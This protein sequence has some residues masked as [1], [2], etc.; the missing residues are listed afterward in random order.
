[1]NIAYLDPAYSRYFHAL[2][3]A[4]RARTGGS[5]VALLS[6]PAYRLYTGDDRTVVWKPGVPERISELPPEFAHATWAPLNDAAS[7][8]AFS[9][10]VEWF[11]Q[12]FLEERIE[13]CLVFSDARPFSVA[14][15][16][17]AQELGVVILYFERGAFRYST[18]SLSTLGLNSRF[19]LRRAQTLPGI[20][21][22]PASEALKRRSVE[23]WLRLRFAKF[24]ARNALACL[25]DRDRGRIQHKRYAIRPYLRLAVAQWWAEHHHE[26]TSAD[27]LTSLSGHPLVIL[28]LQLETDSQL[29]LHSPFSGNQHFI[30]FVVAQVRNLVPEAVVL[31]KRHPM[32]ASRY[33]VPPGARM[34]G[35]NLARFHAARPIFVCV[36]STVGFEALVRGERVI[37][38]APSFYA[39]AQ[40]LAMASLGT[41]V[42][43]FEQVLRTS[44]DTPAGQQL[45]ASVLQCYQA[46]GDAWAYTAQDIEGTAEVV[47]KHC[48]A[49]RLT[50][51]PTVRSAPRVRAAAADHA[52]A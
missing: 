29:V 15:R 41:F 24:I 21:G 9:H 13:L 18:S 17:A 37:C 46:P 35:G 34:V 23:P 31:L 49:A 7:V 6:S 20:V 33:R 2:A 51:V 39:D 4:L 47:L 40:M 42:Q 8:A 10:A 11:R 32:D 38:F 36:N 45:K 19:S 5:T 48:R 27:E 26:H 43:R 22:V 12:R 30:D 52:I 44:G 3:K 16:L 28:P 50:V 14:A 1:M 25:V